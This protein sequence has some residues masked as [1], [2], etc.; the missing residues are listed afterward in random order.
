MSLDMRKPVWGVSHQVIPKPAYSA[1]ET[2]Y[3][4]EILLMA[5]LDVITLSN[6]QITKADCMD[7]QALVCVFVVH[8]VFLHRGPAAGHMSTP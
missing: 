2:T 6:E 7:A 8:K 1:A 5:S 3:N 4:I